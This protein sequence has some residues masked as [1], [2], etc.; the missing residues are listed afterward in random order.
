MHLIRLVD[1][2]HGSNQVCTQ[3]FGGDL[4]VE[5]DFSYYKLWSRSSVLTYQYY[6]LSGTWWS[7]LDFRPAEFQ[8]IAHGGDSVQS[9]HNGLP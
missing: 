7:I 9:I 3:N 5:N 8:K 4:G 1:H 6:M 2:S